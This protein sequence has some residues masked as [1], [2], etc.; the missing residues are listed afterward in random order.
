MV[1]EWVG[2]GSVTNKKGGSAFFVANGIGAFF[3]N[4]NGANTVI[5]CWV[6]YIL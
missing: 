5:Y 6:E 1:G 3:G 4:S 2:F